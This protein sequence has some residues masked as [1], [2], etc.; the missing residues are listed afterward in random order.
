MATYVLVIKCTEDSSITV[1]K[2]GEIYLQKGLYCYIGSARRGLNQRIKRH[3]ARKKKVHW[4]I[5]YILSPQVAM[6]E[7]V[8]ISDYEQECYTA[9]KLV[10]SLKLYLVRKKIGSSDC[11]CPAH[12]YLIRESAATLIN[13]LKEIGFR[14]WK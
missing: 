11:N 3:M 7:S 6:I 14:Q 10:H 13:F 2:R 5:D 1:G 4:H 12:F 8:W 9:Q